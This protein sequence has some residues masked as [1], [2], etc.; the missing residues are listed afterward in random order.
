MSRC[1]CSGSTCSC[2]IQGGGGV[3]VLGSGT[4]ASPY[5][6]ATDLNLAV[7]DTATVQMALSGSGSPSDPF[8]LAAT[9]SISLDE[10]EGVN[11]TN[12]TTGYVLARQADGSFAMVP[13]STAAVGAITV[14]NGIAGDGSSGSPLS[15]KLAPSSGL[16]LD[17]NGLKVA[18]AGN[19]SAYSPQ[20]HTTDTTGPQTL[21]SQSSLT[22]RYKQDGDTVHFAAEADFSANFNPPGG[23]FSITLPVPARPNWRQPIL[24]QGFFTDDGSDPAA[25]G[26]RGDRIGLGD[27]EA[28]GLYINRIRFDRGGYLGRVSSIYPRWRAYRVRMFFNGSYEAA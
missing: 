3:S 13:P 10:I 14:G 26:T 18:S 6:I 16:V 27:I 17:G 1:G 23:H 24:A 11:A 7:I 20:L 2:V 8:L 4:I 21:D 15:V 5:V 12:M 22:G 19:W 25:G 9:A 28:T